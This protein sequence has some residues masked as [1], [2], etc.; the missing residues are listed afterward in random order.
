MQ[1][2]IKWVVHPNRRKKTGW[3]QGARQP[4]E[5]SDYFKYLCEVGAGW[6]D[7]RNKTN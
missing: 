7:K 4:V 5:P 6:N 3:V 1:H 2:K